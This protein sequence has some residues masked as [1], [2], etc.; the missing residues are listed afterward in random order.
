MGSPFAEDF[1]K[2]FIT[3]ELEKMRLMGEISWRQKSWALWLKEGNQCT[4]F[5]HQVGDSHWRRNNALEML[6]V[7]GHVV[8]DRDVIKSHMVNY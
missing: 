3:L 1:R 4:E 6:Q 5:F 2:S 7:N 8:T